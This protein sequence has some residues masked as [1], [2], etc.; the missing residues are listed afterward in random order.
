MNSHS[1]MA[2]LAFIIFVRDKPTEDCSGLEK[3]VK[4]CIE[5]KDIVF[6]PNSSKELVKKGVVRNDD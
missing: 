4:E 5:K 3:Y 2:Y 6:F 1:P